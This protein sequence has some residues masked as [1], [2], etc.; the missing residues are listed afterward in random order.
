MVENEAVKER[1]ALFTMTHAEIDLKSMYF[2]KQLLLKVFQISFCLHK[3]FFFGGRVLFNFVQLTW[4]ENKRLSD[5]TKTTLT[6]QYS[7]SYYFMLYLL[8][9]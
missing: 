4:I 5:M 9:K 2:F 3:V 6:T 8:I 7:Y 1:L